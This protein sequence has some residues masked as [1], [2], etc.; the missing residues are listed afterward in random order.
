MFKDVNS[1]KNFCIDLRKTILEISFNAGAS[2]SHFGGGLSLVEIIAVLFSNY[3]NLSQDFAD[4][5]RN[6]FVLSKGHGVLPY[7]AALYHFGF[8]KKNDL[9]FFEKTQG[10]LFGHPVKNLEH[11][12][13]YSTGSLGLGIG[14]SVGLSLAFK[15]KKTNNHV[16]CIIGDGE[17]N[18]GSVW[19]AAMSASHH[20]LDNLTVIL[21]HNGYQQTGSNNEILKVNSLNNKWK[22]FGFDVIEINGH[23]IVEIINA[24]D[25]KN[26]NSPKL[27]LAKTVKGKGFSFSE[28]NNEWHH[29]VLTKSMYDLGLKEL[30]G[31]NWFKKN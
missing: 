4:I 15:K 5:K 16:Y 10:F 21:D 14:L 27:I 13:E 12:I 11:A 23:D 22:S 9:N 24:L 28:N 7:Y 19:E 6:K 17:C 29:K 8:I 2:S 3:L 18:E 30:Y 31:N 20:N 25:K 26:K 1:L